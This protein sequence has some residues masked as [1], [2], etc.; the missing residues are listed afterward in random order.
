MQPNR[1]KNSHTFSHKFRK[2]RKSLVCH[3]S[4]KTCLI[5][6]FCL[7]LN[8]FSFIRFSCFDIIR[9]ISEGLF[10]NTLKLLVLKEEKRTFNSTFRKGLFISS[11]MFQMSKPIV[12]DV[13]Y[14]V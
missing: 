1:K 9:T 5:L 11:Q 8:C 13:Y 4:E 7:Y 14:N 12:Y 3:L 2:Q 10:S 6:Q